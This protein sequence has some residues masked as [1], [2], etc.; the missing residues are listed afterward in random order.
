MICKHCGHTIYRIVLPPPEGPDMRGVN[1]LTHAF[2][3]FCPARDVGTPEHSDI[4][5]TVATKE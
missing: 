2:G 1:N 4:V 3:V 5:F